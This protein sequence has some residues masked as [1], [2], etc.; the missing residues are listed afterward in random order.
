MC[1]INFLVPFN[2]QTFFG[3]F[4]FVLQALKLLQ[5]AKKTV[6]PVTPKMSITLNGRKVFKTHD[7]SKEEEDSDE[8]DDIADFERK[9]Q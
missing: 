6:T 9:I 8:G 1:C 2:G 3:S 7:D 4:C 5:K